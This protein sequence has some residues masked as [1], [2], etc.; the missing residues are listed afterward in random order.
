MLIYM[1]QTVQL[2][3]KINPKQTLEVFKDQELN[4][5]ESGLQY[6]KIKNR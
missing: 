2:M 1:Y 4:E 6:F 5:T 3:V